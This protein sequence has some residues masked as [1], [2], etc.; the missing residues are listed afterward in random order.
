[1]TLNELQ[2]KAI[3][4]A[5]S[6][7]NVFITGSAG[8]GKS[9]LIRL[10][11]RHLPKAVLCSTTG[12]GAT[13]I[14]GQ[15][16]HS[17]LEIKLCKDPVAKMVTNPSILR[18][19][20][21]LSI[22]IIDEI[23]MLSDEI[24]EKINEVAKIA[25]ENDLPFGGVQLIFS[26]DFLQL[27]PV[28]GRFVFHSEAWKEMNFHVIEL[29]EIMRQNDPSFILHLQNIRKG[30]LTDET[31]A[32]F[33]GRTLE[34]QKEQLRASAIRPTV[35]FSHKANVEK[36]NQ[37][38]IQKLLETEKEYK[39]KC[40]YFNARG[41]PIEEKS[42]HVSNEISLCVGA[43]VILIANI[44]VK[45]GL[46]NG[47]RGVIREFQ[48]GFPVVEFMNGIKQQ[49]GNYTWEVHKNGK[50]VF[51]YRQ[52]PLILGWA[53]TIH[54]SQGMT[55]DCA[56]IDIS[57]CFENGQAYV[58]MSRARTI[59]SLFLIRVDWSKIHTSADALKFY[60][61]SNDI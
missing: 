34:Q 56:A 57:N 61:S 46:A 10:L 22:L 47:S 14:G 7:K 4:L 60:K 9:F 25:K 13:L 29:T 55:L 2:K 51:T 12:I 19:F 28:E 20:K 8:T 32:F 23:S 48:G 40:Q 33:E 6:G 42:S 18:A 5:L 41:S 3:S 58:A 50:L 52:I 49:I 45:K 59:E 16:L 17:A 27:P 54:K 24:F 35:I 43:Q 31:K 21:K 1:M 15:T 26:G 53:I 11:N 37:T 36:F 39:Y 44:A 30:I 38:K